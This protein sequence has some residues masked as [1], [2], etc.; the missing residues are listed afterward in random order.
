[1][2]ED[3]RKYLD[4]IPHEIQDLVWDGQKIAA[5]KAVREWKG[6][7]L[8]D[9][10]DWVEHMSGQLS[11]LNGEMPVKQSSGCMSLIT[12]AVTLSTAAFLY[13]QNL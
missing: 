13:L 5:I 12:V 10:K 11:E 2:P 1:M 8:K 6:L 3:E 4:D 9:S 7:G